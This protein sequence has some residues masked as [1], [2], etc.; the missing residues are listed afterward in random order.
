VFLYLVL[1]SF[2]SNSVGLDLIGE[3]AITY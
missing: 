3:R 2:V 1:E